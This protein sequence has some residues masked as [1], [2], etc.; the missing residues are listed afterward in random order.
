MSEIRW[1]AFRKMSWV[2]T[3]WERLWLRLF[4]VT[5]IKPGS[6]FAIRRDGRVLE[7][8]LDGQRLAA[9]R[10]RPDYSG[11]KVIHELRD[12]LRV[13]AT[14]VRSG[15]L[16]GLEGIKGTSLMGAVGPVVGFE[17]RP[18]PRTLHNRLEQYFM[19]G[20]DAVYHPGGLRRH[21]M[22]RWPVESWMSAEELLRRY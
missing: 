19:V 12:D 16:S 3:A 17:A 5:P 6:V 2:W 11:F 18:L 22:R 21:S 20:L 13:I 1:R 9:M 14:R 7:L 4:P 8:H 15:E 10:R